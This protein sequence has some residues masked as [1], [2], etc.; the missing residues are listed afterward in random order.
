MDNHDQQPT[1]Q[2]SAIFASQECTQ[3]QSSVEPWSGLIPP[4]GHFLLKFEC[5]EREAREAADGDATAPNIQLS[6]PNLDDAGKS[7]H[8]LGQTALKVSN[9]MDPDSMDSR[10]LEHEEHMEELPPPGYHTA[11]SPQAQEASAAHLFAGNIVRRLNLVTLNAPWPSFHLI[12]AGKASNPFVSAGDINDHEKCRLLSRADTGAN[13]EVFVEESP[14]SANLQLQHTTFRPRTIDQGSSQ[15]A[16]CLE[17]SH[18]TSQKR[19]RI[20]SPSRFVE[21]DNEKEVGFV[22]IKWEVFGTLEWISPPPPWQLTPSDMDGCIRRGA[23]GSMASWEAPRFDP[24]GMTLRKKSLRVF[25]E[26]VGN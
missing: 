15:D 9:H 20:Q 21:S 2:Q 6:S 12:V 16:S 4:L 1:V 18:L 26:G 13:N 23:T 19:R 5:W 14:E 24:R 25:V 8:E 22:Y 3:K 11:P 17:A 7:K 10:V